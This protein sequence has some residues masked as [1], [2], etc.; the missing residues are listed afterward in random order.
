M[1]LTIPFL[2]LLV[3]LLAFS[4]CQNVEDL[5]NAEVISGDAEFAIPLVRA[6]TTIDSLVENFDSLTFLEFDPDGLIHLRYIGDVLTQTAEEFLLA[7]RDS[8]PLAIPI[9]DTVFE[10]PFSS[11][12]QLEVDKAIY[13]KGTVSLAINTSHI[14]P[15][16][17]TVR[18]PQATK[19][20]QVM[21]VNFPFVG[22]TLNPMNPAGNVIFSKGFGEYVDMAG[23][24]LEPVDGNIFLEYD[25][26]DEDGQRLLFDSLFLISQEIFFGYLEGYLGDFTH[27]GTQDTIEIDFFDSWTQ[28]DVYFEDP[29][30]LIHIENSFGVPT[31]SKID[32][33]DILTADGQ[34]IRLE[35]DFINDAQNGIDFPAPDTPGEKASTTFSFNTSNSNIAEVLGSRP[36]AL[37]YKV[38]ARMN[39][40]EDPTLRG[41]ITD[42][43]FYKI[44]VEVDLPL[45][46][47][48]SGFAVADTFDVDF[49]SYNDVKEAELKIIS[50]NGMPLDI[51]A[52]VYFL[53]DKKEAVDSLFETPIRLIEAAAVDNEGNV[54]APTTG[55]IF[56]TLNEAKFKKIRDSKLL[57]L[58]TAFST[59]G[60]GTSSVRATKGQTVDIRMGL[61]LTQ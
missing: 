59:A 27:R 32:T 13:K 47:R 33:F 4:A 30:I 40:D 17:L 34:R 48:A 2:S 16:D 51:D 18:L 26:F 58:Q 12:D 19:D 43:S 61:K 28:G 21:T 1:K 9:L 54:I 57:A 41:F 52:Q 5:A 39:P 15:V 8:V 24:V 23:Y 31:R 6:T 35:S 3:F 49:S 60:N 50:D 45:H 56:V 44:Q 53:N 11:P 20:G 38:D 25:A 29:E 46:A 10:L 22:P 55:T 36:I 14:G 42:S 37:V 7:A